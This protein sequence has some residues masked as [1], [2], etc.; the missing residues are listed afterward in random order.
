M[1]LALGFTSGG[2]IYDK[3]YRLVSLT[4]NRVKSTSALPG[5]SATRRQGAKPIQF[6]RQAGASAVLLTLT[7]WF[8]SAGMAT[9]IHWGRASFARGTHRFGPVRSAALMVRITSLM[10]TLHLLRILLWAAFYRWFCLSSWESSFYFSTASYSTVGYGDIVL[11]QMW[12][13][14]SPVESVT[15]VLMCGLSVSYLFFIVRRL[16]ERE[17]WSSAELAQPVP[18]PVAARKNVS[19]DNC[20]G[21]QGTPDFPCDR[22]N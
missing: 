16:V 1:L 22:L 8:Q 18:E 12:R 3:S 2:A 15:G 13:T 14:L 17:A 11:P 10:I 20:A 21:V 19:T 7:L 4:Q 5:R 9:L 6:L